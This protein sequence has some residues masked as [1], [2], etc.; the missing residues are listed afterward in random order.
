M[1][2]QLPVEKVNL[3]A[4]CGFGLEEIVAKE[5]E[6]L[7]F[8]GIEL[9]RGGVRYVS[10]INGIYLSNLSLRAASRVLIVLKTFSSKNNAMLYDQVRRVH[11]MDYLNPDTTFAIETKG[12]VEGMQDINSLPFAGLKIKDAIVDE[13]RQKAGDRPNVDLRTPDVKIHAFFE[14]GKCT[15]SLD[16]SGRPLHE[17]GYRKEEGEAPLKET[18]AAA[19]ILAS[20]YNGDGPFVDLMCGSGTLLTEAMLIATNTAPGLL[21]DHF[22]FEKLPFF[23]ASEYN[24]VREKLQGQIKVIKSAVAFGFDESSRTL[25]RA[26][27]NLENLGLERAVKLERRSIDEWLQMGE[28]N[29]GKPGWVMANPPYGERLMGVPNAPAKSLRGINLTLRPEVVQNIEAEN[30]ELQALYKTLGDVFKQKF[31]GY[32]A[33]VFTGS[34]LGMKSVGLKTTRRIVLYNGS[35]E[36]RLLRYDLY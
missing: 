21:R 25:E 31:K 35:L 1:V 18:L 20:G 33:F 26:R 28:V 22:R 34:K 11:W 24:A 16:T 19:L 23:K 10:D 8:S 5:L 15:L 27:K 36:C 6:N 7:G 17:R 29:F 30:P 9:G 3:F 32:K 2:D 4:V 12:S 13:L 14:G